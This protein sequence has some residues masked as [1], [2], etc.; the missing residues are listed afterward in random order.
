MKKRIGVLLSGC[1]FRD[2]AEINEAVLTLLSIDM[3]GAEAVCMA[4]DV[5]QAR[6]INY[7]TGKTENE[8][9]NVLRE[10]ARIA[11]GKI[12][13]LKEISPDDLDA[14]ILPGGSGSTVNF[15][16]RGGSVEKKSVLIPEIA[17]MI[18]KIHEQGKPI[19]AICIAP[20]TVVMALGE[21]RPEVTIGN[22][23][24]TSAEIEKLGG[25][26]VVCQVDEIHIDRKN[27]IVTTPAYMIG[28]GIR[29]VYQGIDRLVEAVIALC[30]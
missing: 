17:G 29:D 30:S 22:C 16:E 2:G 24:R 15:I 6:V 23:R 14:L 8:K 9:R 10:S 18:Q 26:H 1:G 4:P 20:K 21:S 25:I 27:R 28:P 5:D 3:R 12:K 19:G 13:T 7:L 11:R